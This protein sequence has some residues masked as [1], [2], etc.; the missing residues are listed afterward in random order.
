MYVTAQDLIGL[1]GAVDFMP[2]FTIPIGWWMSLGLTGI[3]L[4]QAKI[5][6][7]VHH[8]VKPIDSTKPTIRFRQ[9]TIAVSRIEVDGIFN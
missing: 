2:M 6:R 1:A 9:S 7:E 5:A 3:V 4:K 8:L